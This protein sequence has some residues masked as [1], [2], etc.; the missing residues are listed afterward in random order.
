MLM[1]VVILANHFLTS[2]QVPE[3]IKK[4]DPDLAEEMQKQRKEDIKQV[5]KIYRKNSDKVLK[6]VEKKIEESLNE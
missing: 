3:K 5:G 4:S 2:C 6:K 1:S